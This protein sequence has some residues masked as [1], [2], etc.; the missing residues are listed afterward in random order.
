MYTEYGDLVSVENLCEMLS[1][2]KNSA[3]K[4]LAS[5]ELKSFRYN[6]V[7]KIPKQGVIEYVLK[8]SK[9]A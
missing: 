8:Q 4:L 2:G 3:Y 7:W 1:I 6:R 5:G 9:L